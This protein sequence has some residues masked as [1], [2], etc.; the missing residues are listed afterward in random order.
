METNN[1]C[2][3]REGWFQISIHYSLREMA[4]KDSQSNF[5]NCSAWKEGVACEVGETAALGSA[6]KA[7][8]GVIKTA[9]GIRLISRLGVPHVK[10]IRNFTIWDHDAPL[11]CHSCNTSRRAS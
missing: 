2:G 7:R 9:I 11:G 5:P 4:Y 1:G 6:R 10:I 8:G 3:W